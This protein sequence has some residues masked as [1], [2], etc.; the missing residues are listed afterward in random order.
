METISGNISGVVLCKP[1][2]FHDPRGT[3]FESYR[4]DLIQ[5][6]IGHSLALKQGNTSVSN[7][8]VFRGIHFADVPPSQAKYVTVPRGAI[9]DF[10]VDIRVGSSTFGKVESFELNDKNNHSLYIA[11]GLGHGFL[12]LE[13]NTVVSYLVSETFHADREHGINPL[14]PEL[15]IVLPIPLNEAIISEKD[16]NA[17]SLEEAIT[18]GILPN[19]E[20]CKQFYQFLN[21]GQR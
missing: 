21:E 1:K 11:E 12:S 7:K 20:E 6:A 14:D 10:V 16:T 9:I 8:N 13:E 2:R 4:H 17:P 19:W 3:F 5:E 18:S 15:G